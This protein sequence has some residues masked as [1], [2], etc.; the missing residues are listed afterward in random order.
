[1]GKLSTWV[2][3]VCYFLLGM[4]LLAFVQA[5]AYMRWIFLILVPINLTM[6]LQQGVSMDAP[7]LV[8]LLFLFS[9]GYFT[10][11]QS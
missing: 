6:D 4:L 3:H 1:M 9:I 8:T 11:L 10:F 5:P 2:L 7:A